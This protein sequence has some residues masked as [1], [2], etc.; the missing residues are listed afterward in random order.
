MHAYLLTLY[1]GN[2]PLTQKQQRASLKRYQTILKRADAE[3][4]PLKQGKRGRPKLSKGRALLNRLTKH[5]QAVHAFAFV[6]KI[7]F[8]N[9]QA[10]R[11]IRPAKVKQKVCGTFRAVQG[12]KTYARF[13]AL[14]ST[15]RKQHINVF[16]ALRDLFA[17][18]Q[19]I[20]I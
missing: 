5:Q 7:P 1:K 15:L 17:L 18:K 19:A 8:T 13:A 14:I 16:N 20:L 2:L 11:D 12:A 6:D 9:N 10:E 3:E 4:P